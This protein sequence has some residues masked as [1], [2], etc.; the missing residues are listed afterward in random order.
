MNYRRSRPFTLASGIVG[1]AVSALFLLMGIIGFFNSIFSYYY[2]DST[3]IIIWFFCMCFSG[4]ALAFGIITIN[5]S[6]FSSEKYKAWKGGFITFASIE[7]FITL[8]CFILFITFAIYGQ[9]GEALLFLVA[10]A[11]F[12]VTGIFRIIEI[13]KEDTFVTKYEGKEVKEI[14]AVIEETPSLIEDLE[15]AFEMK[16]NGAFTEE[17]YEKVKKALLNK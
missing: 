15:K 16:K 6:K 7:L 12:A 5:A 14:K 1:T 10:C 8:M 17:E 11:G 2:Y 4:A 3:S 9:V 13:C